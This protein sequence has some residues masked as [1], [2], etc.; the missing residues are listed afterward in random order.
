MAV[1]ILTLVIPSHTSAA[2]GRVVEFNERP[3]V[4]CTA[5]L[6]DVGV[7]RMPEDQPGFVRSTRLVQLANG[8]VVAS[9]LDEKGKVAIFSSKLAFE[10]LIGTAGNGPGEMGDVSSLYGLGPDSVVVACCG[11]TRLT[12]FQSNGHVIASRSVRVAVDDALWFRGGRVIANGPVSTASGAGHPLHVM[13]NWVVTRS[14]GG[15]TNATLPADRATQRRLLARYPGDESRFLALPP[16][17]YDIELWSTQG[18]LLETWKRRPA[19]F[20]QW[21]SVNRMPPWM[22]RPATQL[23]ALWWLDSKTLVVMAS[24]P[25]ANW[26]PE[27][28]APKVGA[29][30]PSLEVTERLIDRKLD[31]LDVSTRRSIATLLVPAN[32]SG[33]LAP[34]RLYAVEEDEVGQFAFRIWRIAVPR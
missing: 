31:V 13:E 7:V 24:L 20:Q 29:L 1:F 17:R 19:W 11:G 18:V 32:A 16:N 23:Q 15:T 12:V 6:T 30:F 21:T 22:E 33:V 3:C 10:R 28:F 26:K 2:Q 34:D 5:T 25:D 14:F 9:P 4:R 8:K 27:A